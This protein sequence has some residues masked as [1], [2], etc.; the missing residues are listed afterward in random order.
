[1]R[2]LFLSMLLYVNLA[3]AVGPDNI[4]TIDRQLW[5]EA[6]NN[7]QAFDLASAHEIRM[8]TRVIAQTSLETKADIQQFTGIENVNVDSVHKWVKKTI[9]ILLE[10]YQHACVQ[11]TNQWDE[12][13][14]ESHKSFS[15]QLQPWAAASEKFYRRYLYEQVRL[16][17]LFPRITSEIETMSAQEVTGFEMQ[18]GEFLLTYDDGPSATRTATLISALNERHIHAFFFL[19]GEQLHHVNP[20]NTLYKQQC[21]GSH[22]YTHHSH[23][24]M[25]DWAKSLSQSRQQLALY[26]KGPYWF[27]PPYGQRTAELL[28]NLDK[29]NEKLMLWNIDSQDWSNKLSTQQ[30]QD[31]VISLM[32]LW[33]RGIIL[34]HDIHPRAVQNLDGLNQVIANTNN[35]WVD[36]RGF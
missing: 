9:N 21:V 6:I 19:L 5:P 29:S 22:G 36:C 10:N 8:F 14:T 2:Y 34:Y 15:T 31:R 25:Q 35:R 28:T 20:E 16:A 30:V 32:L 12:L 27:R 17:A 26:Q 4:A 1:M 13:V 33:R 3:Q 11:C 23:Q 24:K 7:Q 18:D